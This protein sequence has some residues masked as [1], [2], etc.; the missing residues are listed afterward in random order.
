MGWTSISDC[1][2]LK[3]LVEHILKEHDG[4]KEVH[5]ADKELWTIVESPKGDYIL[6]FLLQNEGRHGWS[7]KDISE[8]EGPFYYKCPKR[9]LDLVPVKNQAWRDKVLARNGI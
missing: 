6:V 8:A 4:F 5:L 7:Y 2:T 3:S 9:F 1:K